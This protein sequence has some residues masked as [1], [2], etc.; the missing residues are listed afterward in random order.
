M[1]RVSDYL[2]RVKRIAEG[3][4]NRL[5]D[6]QRTN[7]AFGVR[8]LLS[9]RLPRILSRLLN[10]FAAADELAV[11]GRLD[12]AIAMYEKRLGQVDQAT[13]ASLRRLRFAWASLGDLLALNGHLSKAERVY[14][15]VIAVA[16]EN[17]PAQW[18][19]ANIRRRLGA[20]APRIPLTIHFFS[21]VLN[22]M[23]FI[24]AHIGEMLKL[25]FDWHWHIVEGVASLS[26]DTAWSVAKGGRIDP[27]LHRNGLSNDGTREYLDELARAHPKHVTVYRKPDGR[28]WDGKVE[29]VRAPLDHIGEECLLW[30]IDVDEIWTASM[31]ARMRDKF[32]EDPDR[33]AAYFLCHFFFKNL[34]VV[35][36]NT[37]GNH[38]AYE[39]VRV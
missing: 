34:V 18:G 9:N 3:S 10:P 33:T 27:A 21:I 38:L 1:S 15:R 23:P 24:K 14:N 28:F 35:S 4:W 19:A 31:F 7:G 22:G 32:I 8:R 36:A 39:W 25:P 30:Q 37:Y 26:H 6:E 29:M 13:A 20:T 12:D 5:R 17:L 2:R 16:P 11:E